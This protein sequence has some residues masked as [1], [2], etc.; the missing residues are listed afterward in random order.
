[1]RPVHNRGIYLVTALIFSLLVAMFVGAG[2]LMSLGSNYAAGQSEEALLAELAAQAGIQYCASRL[3]ENP[4][5]RGDGGPG[6]VVDTPDLVIAEERGNVVGLLRDGGRVSQFRVRFN[7]QDDSTDD[8]DGLVDPAPAMW[9]DHRWVSVN[10][11]AS[12]GAAGLPLAD[13]GN[14]EVANS[15]PRPN[16]TPG[17]S[18]TILV[19]G[20]SGVG[21]RNLDA[22]TI[23][24]APTGHV[25]QR[26]LEATY[27]LSA[28]PLFDAAAQAAG[29]LEGSMEDAGTNSNFSVQSVDGSPP[30][31]RSKANVTVAVHDSAATPSL[32]TTPSAGEILVPNTASDFVGNNVNGA[33]VNT[34]NGGFYELTWADVKKADASGDTLAA[35]TYVVWD[36]GSLHYYD[37]DYYD[38]K[39]FIEANPTD[40]GTV[41]TSLPASMTD[42]G[43]GRLTITG[44]I[45]VDS[46]TTSAADLTIIPRGGA[47]ESPKPAGTA[48]PVPAF[49]PGPTPAG[50]SDVKNVYTD[51]NDGSPFHQL[52]LTIADEGVYEHPGG[53]TI[54]WNTTSLYEMNNNKET[55][56]EFLLG[57]PAG[58]SARFTAVNPNPELTVDAGGGFHKVDKV[59]F[60]QWIQG[61]APATGLAPGQLD[62]GGEPATK[63]PADLEIIFDP[64]AGQSATLTAA[65]NVRFGAGIFGQGGSITSEG[66]IRIVGARTD[67]SANPNGVEGVNLYA[68][69]NID[70]LAIVPD[71]ATAATDDYK[72]AD[73]TLNGVV[74]TQKNF[75][76]HM[77]YDDPN[78]TQ[79]G[80]LNIT[81][82]VVAY[83]GDPASDAPGASGDGSISFT[84]RTV[85]LTFDPAYLGGLMQTLPPTPL[86][87]VLYNRIQ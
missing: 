46:S 52:L 5:W 60:D 8:V 65:G 58:A 70:L 66:D 55:A 13:G 25:H 1:M 79:W 42:N 44:D 85:N 6:L 39:T 29:T 73:F 49:E 43:N 38:Y 56:I 48:P 19:E 22:A 7:F 26:V 28:P 30:R 27:R 40:A 2:L 57:P 24:A 4:A 63:T 76:A 45:F 74:Y 23:N 71:D 17:G 69:G 67:L 78:V 37:R 62:L 51:F 50:G 86:E 64:P 9:V 77:G 31:V 33:A 82:A 20:R 12:S 81:G 72:Y 87:Q 68:R 75:T 21:L 61:S 47:Q 3:V 18:A 10:N 84:G 35:G 53:H 80:R 54:K 11:L 15:S 34:E 36:D 59:Y 16:Q 14:F 32:Y 41:V 83:G